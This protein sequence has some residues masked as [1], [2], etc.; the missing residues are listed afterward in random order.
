LAISSAGRLSVV[1]PRQLGLAA[2]SAWISAPIDRQSGVFGY[3]NARQARH[4]LTPVLTTV[5]HGVTTLGWSGLRDIVETIGPQKEES[6]MKRTQILLLALGVAMSSS[7][8]FSVSSP[9]EERIA[10]APEVPAARKG[11]W[12]Y[13]IIDGRKCWYDGKPMLPKTQLYWPE[14]SASEVQPAPAAP[15]KEPAKASAQPAAKP[16]T[17]GRSVSAPAQPVLRPPV[18]TE[19]VALEDA[20]QRS[21]D[22]A[23]PATNEM[24][25]ESRWLGL[26]SRN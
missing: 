23:A 9:A 25:F 17:D 5:I 20:A 12:Y 7:T 21:P 15:S 6:G 14:V 19:P 3:R 18:A 26:H 16:Y 8:I 4:H 22:S 10:C 13:R 1:D 11:H 2:R 24:S